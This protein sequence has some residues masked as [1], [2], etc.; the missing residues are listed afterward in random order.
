MFV[1]ALLLNSYLILG[2]MITFLGFNFSFCSMEVTTSEISSS[3]SFYESIRWNNRGKNIFIN[4]KLSIRARCYS[5]WWNFLPEEETGQISQLFLTSV[6]SVC[7]CGMCT[8]C[9]RLNPAG[10]RKFALKRCSRLGASHGWMPRSLLGIAPRV[11]TGMLQ[12]SILVT[13][14]QTDNLLSR[15][16][17]PLASE[18][19]K[20]L[21]GGLADWL[22]STGFVAFASAAP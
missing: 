12:T 14:L 10:T 9:Y 5:D 18:R 21:P 19:T 3:F 13:L 4:T 8:P 20:E 17:L 2:K 22:S 16:L 7:G 15:I 1:S 11:R 6:E